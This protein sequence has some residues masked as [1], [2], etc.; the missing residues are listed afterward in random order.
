MSATQASLYQNIPRGVSY[1]LEQFWGELR[2]EFMG[3]NTHPHS[4]LITKREY[5]KF[6]DEIR[7]QIREDLKEQVVLVNVVGVVAL[8]N[9]HEVIL[10]LKVKMDI[11]NRWRKKFGLSPISNPY[12]LCCYLCKDVFDD[13][14]ETIVTEE[15][16]KRDRYI[17]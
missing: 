14:L 8:S 16:G 9:P 11:V 13:T 17:V 2:C 3:V 5:S 12:I 6:S 1:Y 10:G 15:T 7:K 4:T